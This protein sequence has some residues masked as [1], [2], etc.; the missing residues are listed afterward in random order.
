MTVIRVAAEL[1]RRGSQDESYAIDLDDAVQADEALRIALLNDPIEPAEWGLLKTGEWLWFA[2]WRQEAGGATDASLLALLDRD[3]QSGSREAR[4][5]L[6]GLALQDREAIELAPVAGTRSIDT[7]VLG[8]VRQHVLE[9]PD[10]TEV[11][12]DLLQYATPVSWFGLRVIL[13]GQ[14]R[15]DVSVLLSEFS[16]R[17]GLSPEVRRSWSVGDDSE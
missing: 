9:F 15:E 8:W 16:E 7:P 5:R 3:L 1:I 13:L 11:V 12:N 2:Q 6:R 14:R 4:Y 17:R 10:P